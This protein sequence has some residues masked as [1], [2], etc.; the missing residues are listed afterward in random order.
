MTTNTIET[1]GC[2]LA[3]AELQTAVGGRKNRA[4]RQARKFWKQH[5]SSQPPVAIGD[6]GVTIDGV[7]TGGPAPAPFDPFKPVPGADAIS[8]PQMPG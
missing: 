1:I 4:Q 2:N 6:G 8:F 3:D 7:W 5:K